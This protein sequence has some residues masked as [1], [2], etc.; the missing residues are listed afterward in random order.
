[1]FKEQVLSSRKLSFGLTS[2]SQSLI[3]LEA[4]VEAL[5]L[6]ASPLGWGVELK[7]RAS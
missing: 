1:M 2:E 6:P 3:Q 5:L 7:C 4:A